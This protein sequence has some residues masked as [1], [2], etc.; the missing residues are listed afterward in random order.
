[1]AAE[2]DPFA[3]SGRDVSESGEE[4]SGDGDVRAVALGVAEVDAEVWQV[5]DRERAG[6]LHDAVRLVDHGVE[7]VV[8][9]VVDLA[10]DLFQE[11]FESD[12][13]VDTA[14]FVDDE[15]ELLA[16]GRISRIPSATVRVSGSSVG[17]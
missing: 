6:Q 2:G 1:M 5:V 16:V 12:D 13:A 3:G 9:V 4:E 7:V 8:G 15:G 17:G 10:D 14:A 11:V